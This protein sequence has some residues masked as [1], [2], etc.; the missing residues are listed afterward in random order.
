MILNDATKTIF[1]KLLR[2]NDEFLHDEFF[3]TDTETYTIDNI[4]YEAD[5]STANQ[6]RRLTNVI[7]LFLQR[8][9]QLPEIPG[10]N[11]LLHDTSVSYIADDPICSMSFKSVLSLTGWEIE[12]DYC[13]SSRSFLDEHSANMVLDISREL[14]DEYIDKQETD[15]FERATCLL[16]D[17][18][19]Y[20]I[21]NK[22]IDIIMKNIKLLEEKTPQLV[23]RFNTL[24]S[25]VSVYMSSATYVYN[26]Y[27]KKGIHFICASEY[28][29]D[30]WNCYKEET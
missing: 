29:Y 21:H 10:Y 13:F 7:L 15:P 17:V 14:Q 25:E 9:H 23:E 3:L 24:L 16:D 20:S 4:K 18:F 5:I 2:Y 1:K 26:Y 30:G 27:D 11:M 19:F 6:F 12:E 22:S 8:N 28:F